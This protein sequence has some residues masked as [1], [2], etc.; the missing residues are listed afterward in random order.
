MLACYI[1]TFCYHAISH[2]T[3]TDHPGMCCRGLCKLVQWVSYI[4][5]DDDPWSGSPTLRALDRVPAYIYIYIYI[6]IM[7]TSILKS[8]RL[9]TLRWPAAVLFGK[10]AFSEFLNMPIFWKSGFYNFSSDFCQNG[11]PGQTTLPIWKVSKFCAKPRS[12]NV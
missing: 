12:Q 11:S 8:F 5:S 6:H 4:E 3:L 10:L 2:L 1:T 7:Y 9:P